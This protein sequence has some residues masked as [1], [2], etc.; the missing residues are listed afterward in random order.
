MTGGVTPETATDQQCEHCGRWFSA[1]GIDSH[2]G[3]CDLSDVDAVVVPVVDHGAA[4]LLD[5]DLD[6]HDAF[7]DE[8]PTP[9]HDVDAVEGPT[10][11][12]GGGQ[13]V[14]EGATVTDGGRA[15]A[16]PEPD[17]EREPA[18]PTDDV[19]DDDEQRDGSDD[20]DDHDHDDVECP[21]C[22]RATGDDPDDLD[23][24]AIYRCPHD[25]CGARF[26]WRADA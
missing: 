22:E 19:V 16:P 11:D 13:P 23:D 12:E 3:A 15:M 5:D 18:P 4:D 25:D 17:V 8:G 2:E 20:V 7:A 9:G 26:R 14:D 10:P 1:Q 24:G 6:E 21:T